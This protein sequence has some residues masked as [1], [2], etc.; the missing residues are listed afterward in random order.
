[1][2]FDDVWEA[3]FVPSPAVTPDSDV[4]FGQWA[5]EWAGMGTLERTLE[6]AKQGG[7]QS[8]I[9]ELPQGW[10]NFA[11]I[12]EWAVTNRLACDYTKACRKV[13]P[14]VTKSETQ[15]KP[16]RK[17][18]IPAPNDGNLAASRPE[19][20]LVL[21]AD[22]DKSHLR[23]VVDAVGEGRP[24]RVPTDHGGPRPSRHILNPSLRGGLRFDRGEWIDELQ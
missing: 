24:A 7:L 19:V 11:Q 14:P 20:L 3:G 12:Q 4:P 9:N 17:L 15:V 8:A 1:M 2:P 23:F 16:E 22:R 10:T 13:L 5:F 18:K 21:R 6:H